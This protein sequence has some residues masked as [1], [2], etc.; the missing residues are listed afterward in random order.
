[1]AK[2]IKGFA[3]RE[4]AR[5]T[6]KE[7]ALANLA[8]DFKKLNDTIEKLQNTPDGWTQEDQDALDSIEAQSDSIT[9]RFEALAGLTPEDPE[10]A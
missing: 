8:G 10:P 7:A 9:S 3:E 1:M 6:R 2:D 4:G 5:N